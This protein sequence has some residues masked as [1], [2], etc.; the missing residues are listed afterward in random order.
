MGLVAVVVAAGVAALRLLS[1]R[2]AVAAALVWGM[3]WVAVG[4]LAG[5]PGDALV[6]WAAALGAVVVLWAAMR[7]RPVGGVLDDAA[8]ADTRIG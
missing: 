2:L 7:S 3:A 4:R 6:G 5:E 1:G 8:G